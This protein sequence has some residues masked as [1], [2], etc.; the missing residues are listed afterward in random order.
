MFKFIVFAIFCLTSVSVF[1]DTK[2]DDFCNNYKEVT[3]SGASYHFTERTPYAK[4][5]GYNWANYGIGINCSKNNFGQ[6]Y[7]EIQIGIL[8]NSFREPS[9]ILSYGLLYPVFDKLSL[10]LKAIVASGYQNAPTNF[11]GFIASPLISA[12]ILVTED[13][14]LNVSFIP[15]FTTTS[16][17]VDGFIYGNIGFKF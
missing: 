7:D 2:S 12:K 3:I 9:G 10:G 13:V 14:S 5:N 6:W 16:S 4:S 1:A 8:E 15:S 17:Y 11:S